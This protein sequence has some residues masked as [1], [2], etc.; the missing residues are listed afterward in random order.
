[1]NLVLHFSSKPNFTLESFIHFP[2]KNDE[3]SNI[4]PIPSFNG[5]SNANWG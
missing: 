2:L 4:S 3:S 5:F 1:M